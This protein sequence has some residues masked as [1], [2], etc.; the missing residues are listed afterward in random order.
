VKA[1]T[2]RLCGMVVPRQASGDVAP[3]SP[4]PRD[5]AY[6]T[7]K[8]ATSFGKKKP[9]EAKVL[10]KVVVAEVVAPAAAAAATT[11]R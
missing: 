4:W 7:P 3:L 10:S 11:T 5:D 1:D 8:P 9:E 6:E 2:R